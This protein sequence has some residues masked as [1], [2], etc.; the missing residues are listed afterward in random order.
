MYS[1]FVP[2]LSWPPLF[3]GWI[4]DDKKLKTQNPELSKPRP[5]QFC[6]FIDQLPRPGK[7]S[8]SF[9]SSGLILIGSKESGEEG[10]VQGCNI[11]PCVCLVA[12]AKIKPASGPQHRPRAGLRGQHRA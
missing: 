7:G 12:Q 6:V 1:I 2:I 4:G 11:V 8:L 9:V 10:L 3:G 5:D